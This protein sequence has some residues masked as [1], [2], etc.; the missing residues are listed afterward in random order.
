[1]YDNTLLLFVFLIYLLQFRINKNKK[2]QKIIINCTLIK[3]EA[4][5]SSSNSDNNDNNNEDNDEN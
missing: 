2:H 1:M 4:N 5:N 3:L